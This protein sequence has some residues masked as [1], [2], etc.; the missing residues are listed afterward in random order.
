M[1]R[2]ETPLVGRASAKS[3]EHKCGAGNSACRQALQPVEPP[4]K[5]AA[6]MIGRPTK[7]MYAA[8]GSFACR[9]SK[10]RQAKAPALPS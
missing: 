10:R 6:A 5:A 8:L 7:K 4:G 2:F 1:R 3:R 9:F